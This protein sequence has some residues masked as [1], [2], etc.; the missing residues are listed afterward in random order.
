MNDCHSST[1]TLLFFSQKVMVITTTTT[2][3]PVN[4]FILVAHART[5]SD[6]NIQFIY[7]QGNSVADYL[8]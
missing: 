6:L 2:T 1:S 4:I 8:Q 7:T 5:S 3:P